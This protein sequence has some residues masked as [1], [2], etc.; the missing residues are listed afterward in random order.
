MCFRWLKALLV[1]VAVC[2]ERAKEAESRAHRRPQQER[3]KAKGA[4]KEEEEGS[5]RAAK[6]SVVTHCNCLSLYVQNW[7]SAYGCSPRPAQLATW[8]YLV[9]GVT[10]CV[11]L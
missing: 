8:S 9:I 6:V 5:Q 1:Y 4:Q 7:L 10:A 3:Q 11:T 2:G